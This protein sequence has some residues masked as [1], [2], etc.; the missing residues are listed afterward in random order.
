MCRNPL[1]IGIILTRSLAENHHLQLYSSVL[2]SIRSFLLSSLFKAFLHHI[3][4]P[5]LQASV[6]TSSSHLDL[7]LPTFLL[8]LVFA[9][10][11]QLGI[12]SAFMRY[13]WPAHHSIAIHIAVVSFGSLYN[14]YSSEL[15]LLLQISP[16]CIGS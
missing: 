5:I 2:A 10:R 1:T 13:T 7:G 11:S 4:I 14:A 15:Y 8:P 16:F 6:L 12:C 9:Y 3:I